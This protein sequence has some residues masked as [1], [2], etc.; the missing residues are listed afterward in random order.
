MEILSYCDNPKVLFSVFSA[1]HT[2]PDSPP[3]IVDLAVDIVLFNVNMLDRVTDELAISA[4]PKRW[5]EAADILH[6]L[7]QPPSDM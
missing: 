6:G 2:A 4:T 7:H 5:R 3:A 1:I